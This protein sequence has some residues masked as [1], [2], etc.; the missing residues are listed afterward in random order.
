MPFAGK[1]EVGLFKKGDELVVEVG[2]FR[3]HIGLP[4]TL[5]TLVPLR[6]TFEEKTLVVELGE[7]R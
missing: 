7:P 2:V 5:A 3:R 6:A 1:G 4:T